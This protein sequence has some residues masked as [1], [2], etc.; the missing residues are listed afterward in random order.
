MPPLFAL[1]VVRTHRLRQHGL[2]ADCRTVC[3]GIGSWG[4]WPL[5]LKSTLEFKLHMQNY[6]RRV[7]SGDR[8][9]AIEYAKAHFGNHTGRHLKDIQARELRRLAA[10]SSFGLGVRARC[11]LR[12]KCK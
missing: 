4:C 12:F 10:H 8:S 5:Q 3:L 1:L 7:T 6:V 9:G 11:A 2:S